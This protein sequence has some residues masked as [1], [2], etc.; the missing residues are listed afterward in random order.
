MTLQSGSLVQQHGALGVRLSAMGAHLLAGEDGLAVEGVAWACDCGTGEAGGAVADG[1]DDFS[2]SKGRLHDAAQLLA[3]GAV[4]SNAVP[5][6]EHM[7]A[8]AR[9]ML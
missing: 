1:A 2:G 4:P 5:A 3:K 7:R 9:H 6:C 8:H